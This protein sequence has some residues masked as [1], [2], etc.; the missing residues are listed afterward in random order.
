MCRD[1]DIFRQHTPFHKM[2]VV[3]KNKHDEPPGDEVGDQENPGADS[4]DGT[5]ECFQDER[6]NPLQS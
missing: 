3:N 1:I 2:A 6:E 5:W 4:R